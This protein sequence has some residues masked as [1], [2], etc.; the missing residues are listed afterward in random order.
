MMEIIHLSEH[1]GR[2][3]G[4]R[5]LSLDVIVSGL[6]SD[7]AE[8]HGDKGDKTKEDFLEHELEL[9]GW[10]RR[11]GGFER[12]SSSQA[13]LKKFGKAGVT[14]V[15]G[16]AAPGAFWSSDT[17]SRN[18]AVDPSVHG[19]FAR[20]SRSLRA[21]YCLQ[22]VATVHAV[23]VISIST[24]PEL[25]P[26]IARRI[27]LLVAVW[28]AGSGLARAADIA[29]KWTAEF[30][31]QIGPQKYVYEFKVEDDKL[32]G[33]AK[34]DRSMGKGEVALKEI[35]VNGD[36][37]SFLE[38]VSFDGNEVVITYKGKLVGDEM[39]LTREV[40]EFATEQIVAKRVKPPAAAQP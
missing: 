7:D 39:K 22:S 38:K 27:I 17:N 30:D 31:S 16:D 2:G 23:R 26:M 6:Q 5:R 25:F 35:K 11:L 21:E 29:G 18:G 8:E 12:T 32:T 19:S 4:Y 1:D 20:R 14:A 34:F 33:K 37:V 15:E 10:V 36:D 40:G 3:S 9:S 28:L 13:G 24:P